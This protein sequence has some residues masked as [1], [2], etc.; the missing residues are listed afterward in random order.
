VIWTSPQI[1]AFLSVTPYAELLL[2][3]LW[4]GQREGDILRLQVS[5]YD[6]TV[7]RL[8]QRKGYRKGKRNRASIVS[9]PAQGGARRRA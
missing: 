1:G 3:G 6:G 9:D 8:K 5:D 7:I 2:I 4:T